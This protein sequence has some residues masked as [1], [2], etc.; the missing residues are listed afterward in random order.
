ML[1]SEI[2]VSQLKTKLD[3]SSLVLLFTS[4]KDAPVNKSK[5]M[6]QHPNEYIPNSLFF[7]FQNVVV[8]VT[9]SLSNTMPPITVFEREVRKLGINLGSEIVVYDDFGNFCASRVW[10]MLKNMGHEK[11]FVLQGGLEAWISQGL[12]TATSLVSSKAQGDFVARPSRDYQFV[13]RA[14]IAKHVVN[15]TKKPTPLLDARSQTRFSGEEPEAKTHLRAGHIPNS[16]NIYYKQIQQS[17]GSFVSLEELRD[18]F[19]STLASTDNQVPIAFSCGSGVT[20]CILA[21]AA[22]AL[23]HKPL[24]VYDGSWSDWGSQTKLPIATS[25]NNMS[26]TGPNDGL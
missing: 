5:T 22:D 1:K 7:D 13:D 3:Q 25:S 10:F 17:D 21:Q 9:S 26:N 20:A 4:M 12:D 18:I 23:G 8:D 2:S 6:E 19:N 15:S 24:Y 11:V 16:V 14:F